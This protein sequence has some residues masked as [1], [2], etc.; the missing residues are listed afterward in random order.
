MKNKLII[1]PLVFLSAACNLFG[2]PTAGGVVKT[3]NGGADW[4]FSNVVKTGEKDSASLSGA[5]ISKLAFDP[6]NREIVYAASYNA[7]LFRSQNS[8]TDWQ[9]ILSKI[10]VYD[11]A[12]SPFDSK[13]I[14]VAG[15]FG[16]FGKGLKTTDGGASW[17]EIYNEAST[18]NP[19]RA[20]AL[21][22]S[23]PNELLLGTASGN[24]VKSSDGGIS[25][26]L[27]TNFSDRINSVLW[28]NGQIYVLLK[29]KGLLKSSGLSSNF[30]NLTSGLARSSFLESYT[31]ITDKVESFNRVYVDLLS[32]NLIYLTTDKGLYK[33]TDEGK[34]WQKVVLPVKEGAQETRSISV[35]LSSS[36]VV[37]TSIGATIY[38]STDAGQSWQTQSIATKGFINYI[39]IDPK[40]PQIV[41]AGIYFT[42]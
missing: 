27:V 22:P 18:G 20:V 35:A 16:D 31:D 41:Y 6:Q 34:N 25:W 29:S 33:S 42:D 26:Q 37:F 1:L 7:G 2:T 14:Y 21:N 8:G 39:L 38:K 40:L 19:V 11:F 12:I 15:Q 3:V 17:E 13:T 32:S 4:Q 9:K 5:K 23:N 30:E 24:L 28:Q 10:F 36:N